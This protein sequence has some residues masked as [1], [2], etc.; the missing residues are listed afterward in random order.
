M[1]CCWKA[2]RPSEIP[3]LDRNRNAT[4]RSERNTQILQPEPSSKTGRETGVGII[5]YRGDYNE[6]SLTHEDTNVVTKSETVNY[7]R[8]H[9]YE[10][11][12]EHKT[13]PPA[14][15]VEELLAAIELVLQHP[16][17]GYKGGL[18]QFT[19]QTPVWY[20]N[21]GEVSYRKHSGVSVTEGVVNLEWVDVGEDWYH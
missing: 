16:V 15:T 18:F 19:E 7:G 1:G 20:S 14:E 3:Q 8:G 2:F 5:S 21:Y 9:S 11:S 17:E 12:T 4:K 6:A 13:A 10:R